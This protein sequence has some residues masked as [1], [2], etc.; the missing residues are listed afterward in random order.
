MNPSASGWIEKHFPVVLENL[1]DKNWQTNNFYLELRNAGFIY[2][3]TLQTPSYPQSISSKWTIEEKTKI[4]LLDALVVSYYQHGKKKD[5]KACLTKI[6]A[7]YLSIESQHKT[8]KKLFKFKSSPASQLE[9]L[10]HA[11]IQTNQNLLQKNFSNLLTNALLYLDVLGFETFLKTKQSPLAYLK[12]T[13]TNIVNTMYLAFQQKAEKNIYEALVLKLLQNSLRYTNQKPSVKH[14]QEIKFK[15]LKNTNAKKYVL[16]LACITVY[17]DQ[18]IEKTEKLFIENLGKKLGFSLQDTHQ[19]LESTQEFLKTHKAEI[20][21]FE[22]S[23]AIHQAYKNTHKL[24]KLLILRNKN[25]LLTEIKES[26]ALVVLLS[27][28]THSNLTEKE[29][30]IVKEQL[31]DIC[32]S[33]PSLAIFVLPGGS[34]LLPILIK[35][36]PQLL[37]SAFNE[38]R[39]T[40]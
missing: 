4:N 35:F 21:Y 26:G 9:N 31:L 6:C 37:P 1:H 17:N 33:V 25:R 36:I 24:V 5:A 28:S 12:N 38:N 8:F 27:K 11:R 7:Y 34:I 39:I 29:R 14:L 32:K 3:N 13:E 19:A 22:N 20:A 23:N 15:A 40:N 10:L 16:D 2:A 30:K 18:A